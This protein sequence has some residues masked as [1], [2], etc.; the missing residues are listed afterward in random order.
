MYELTLMLVG[1]WII[2]RYRVADKLVMN[3]LGW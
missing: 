3:L 1:T 2:A